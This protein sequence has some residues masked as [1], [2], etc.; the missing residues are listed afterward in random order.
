MVKRLA[1]LSDVHVETTNAA[2][3]KLVARICKDM[4]V[5][6]EVDLGDYCS[7]DALNH[8]KPIKINRMT[9][10]K[11]MDIANRALDLF[12]FMKK[13]VFLY[14]NHGRWL[15]EYVAEHPELEGAI[16]LARDLKL[17]ERGYYIHESDHKPYVTDYA[18]FHHGNAVTSGAA[19]Y[20]ATM[21]PAIYA[22]K[23]Q[24]MVCYGHDHTANVFCSEV[25]T[26]YGCAYLG[27]ERPEY[28]K[29]STPRWQRGFRIIEHDGR[30]ASTTFIPVTYDDRAVIN[31]KLYKGK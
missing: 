26:S 6:E 3:M 12:G 27:A 24:K 2:T 19:K 29:A 31:G 13:R 25:A 16:D 5:T 7:M 15:E 10:G 22:T 4:G 28:L 14:G 11:T 9:Y 8:H 23:K 21:F 30:L 1:V 20:Y 17:K 18:L